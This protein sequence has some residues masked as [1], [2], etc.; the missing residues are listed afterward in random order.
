MG[1][2]DHP[3]AALRPPIPPEIR[4]MPKAPVP[5]PL[6]PYPSLY[7]TL[8]PRWPR[9]VNVACAIAMDG[10]HAAARNTHFRMMQHSPPEPPVERQSTAR[11]G[12]STRV[13]ESY[14]QP[15]ANLFR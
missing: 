6:T 15:A 2:W 14:G 9:P 3:Q 12:K 8:D 4:L 10:Q 7:E 5:S 1:L 13:R 11:C